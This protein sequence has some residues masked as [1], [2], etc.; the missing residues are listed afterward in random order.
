MSREL[1]LAYT[2]VASV[3]LREWERRGAVRFLPKG[4]RG[5]KIALRSD[6]DAALSVLF[7][8]AAPQEEDFDFG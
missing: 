6:L 3:Q 4:P 1:A 2:G 5:A 7:S 8:T